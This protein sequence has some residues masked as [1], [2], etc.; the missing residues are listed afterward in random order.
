LDQIDSCTDLPDAWHQTLQGLSIFI[1][2]GLEAFQLSGQC[3]L[4]HA[5]TYVWISGAYIKKYL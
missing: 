3:M 5:S 1:R 4:H 2:Q